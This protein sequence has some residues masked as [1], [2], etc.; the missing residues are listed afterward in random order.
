MIE[1]EEELFIFSKLFW[2][3][4]GKCCQNSDKKSL[5]RREC[6]DESK[7]PG[8]VAGWVHSVAGRPGGFVNHNVIRTMRSTL[9]LDN[10]RNSRNIWRLYWRPSLLCGWST[11]RVQD[12]R[13]YLNDEV[14]YAA[15]QPKEVW[16]HYSQNPLSD[17]I[18]AVALLELARLVLSW[19][20]LPF[21][22]LPTFRPWDTLRT[23]NAIEIIGLGA[24]VATFAF[25]VNGDGQRLVFL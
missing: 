8:T 12:S 14:H 2:N 20:V 18:I 19:A 1:L 7:I 6:I 16:R 23:K 15:G 21:G 11:R 13:R 5:K 22:S 4:T 3:P 25:L 9:R 17:A 24:M 10:S